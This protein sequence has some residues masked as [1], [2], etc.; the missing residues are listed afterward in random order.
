MNLCINAR[1]AMPSGGKLTI[2]AENLEIDPVY[3]NTRGNV[4]TGRYILIKV[5]DTGSGISAE[6]LNKIFDPFFTT[7][8]PGKGTGLGLTSVVEIIK[9]HRGLIDVESW[10]GKG[11]SFK[12]Y[13][14]AVD[15]GNTLQSELRQFDPPVG[16]DELILVVDDE[17]TILEISRK[18]LEAHGYRVLVANDGTEAISLFA[19]NKD[20][21]DLVVLDMLMPYMDGPTT[22]RTL[23]KIDPQVKII[24]SSAYSQAT[25]DIDSSEIKAVLVK[26]Y[27]AQVLLTVLADVLKESSGKRRKAGNDG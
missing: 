18:T 11:T 7:K 27:S 5:A 4:S 3:A 21:I 23:K 25:D 6:D 2:S 22:I 26:P 20:D 12:L 10:E 1:D 19:Q 14:P 13:I 24:V 15:A 9:G 8:A 17:A 16:N